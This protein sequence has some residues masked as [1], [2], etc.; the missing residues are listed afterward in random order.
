MKLVIFLPTHERPKMLLNLLK[1]IDRER[2]IA[3]GLCIKLLIFNDGSTMDYSEVKE[4]LF[5]KFS[6]KWFDYPVPHGRQYF[7]KLH[8]KMF[9]ALKDEKD[10][11]YFIQLADDLRL[12]DHFF[13][14]CI[15][16]IVNIDADILNILTVQSHHSS[17]NG[18]IESIKIN[19]IDYFLTN[20]YDCVSIMTPKFFDDI[21]WEAPETPL[22]I[23]EKNPVTGSWVGEYI[24]EKYHNITGKNILQLKY[25][26]VYHLGFTS[27]LNEYQRKLDPCYSVVTP[28]DQELYRKLIEE[29]QLPP[30]KVEGLE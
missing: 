30:P 11:S 28:Y 10:V 20:F 6:F 9:A 3:G 23:W 18:R 27:I 14:R 1:D 17:Y 15:R 21:G 4:Y 29:S 8:N 24:S 13:E 5:D 25:S 2:K 7:W 26:Q 16:S 12:V 19:N 22:S